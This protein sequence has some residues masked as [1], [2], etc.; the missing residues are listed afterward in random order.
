[1]VVAQDRDGD[2]RAQLFLVALDKL[3][4]MRPLT[5]VDRMVARR[6][7]NTLTHCL[8]SA[9]KELC[10]EDLSLQRVMTEEPVPP[11]GAGVGDE[12]T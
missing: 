3:S 12:E 7:F 1:M 6:L 2:E 4:V 8:T 10:G 5:E 9:W 11:L